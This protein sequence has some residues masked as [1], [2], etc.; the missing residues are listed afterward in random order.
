VGHECIDF[1]G[2][3][4]NE[5]TRQMKRAQQVITDTVPCGRF[6]ISDFNQ[7]ISQAMATP[8]RKTKPFAHCNDIATQWFSKSRNP[9]RPHPSQDGDCASSSERARTMA[10]AGNGTA[11]REPISRETT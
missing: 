1:I 8:Q 2:S 10:T 3:S 9:F 11:G 6:S 7:H 5:Q 4:Q